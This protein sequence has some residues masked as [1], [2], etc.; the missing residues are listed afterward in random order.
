MSGLELEVGSQELPATGGSW[1]LGM[2][3]EIHRAPKH[4][5]L[6]RITMYRNATLRTIL[7]NLTKSTPI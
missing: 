3:M 7:H 4:S 2:E 5:D 6:K 1:T